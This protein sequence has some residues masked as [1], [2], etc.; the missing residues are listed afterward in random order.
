MDDYKLAIINDKD[1]GIEKIGSRKNDDLHI[2]CLLNY[3]KEK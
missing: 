3:I 2:I 1:N